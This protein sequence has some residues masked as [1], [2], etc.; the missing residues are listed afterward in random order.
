MD[1]TENDATNTGRTSDDYGSPDNQ[2]HP[3]D[4]AEWD[5][6]TKKDNDEEEEEEEEHEEEDGYE[7]NGDSKKYQKNRRLNSLLSVYEL[8]PQAP[9]LGDWS[10]HETF[11]LLEAW[12]HRF[13]KQGRKSLLFD[14]WQE[15]AKEVS[16]YSK[17]KR[18]DTQCRN[19]LDT[20]SFS[21]FSFTPVP[22]RLPPMVG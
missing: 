14:E 10:E 5:D 9:S 4:E 6:N 15:L 1:D 3:H 17:V 8:A 22:Q 20:S 11:I 13:V 18:T 7:D 16:Q 19:R 21:S 2:K 12:G